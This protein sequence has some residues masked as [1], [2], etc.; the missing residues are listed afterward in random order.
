MPSS[1]NCTDNVSA[2]SYAS[3]GYRDTRS[4]LADLHAKMAAPG[5]DTE[6][7]EL[8]GKYLPHSIAAL[9]AAFKQRVRQQWQ[10]RRA[11]SEPPILALRQHLT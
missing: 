5:E 10:D 11:A 7:A 2:F 9:R 4:E 3:F 1:S 8:N 6:R